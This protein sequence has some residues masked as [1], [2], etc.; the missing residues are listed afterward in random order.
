MVTGEDRVGQVVEATTARPALVPLS[1][2]FGVVSPL[3]DHLSGIAA[4]AVDAVGPPE[5]AD[6]LVALGVV[7]DPQDVD[8]HGGRLH[9]VSNQGSQ[10]LLGPNCRVKGR[11]THLSPRNT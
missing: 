9:A 4:G 2:R 5:L 10:V 1:L 6:H 3:L 11:P 7:G 8:E